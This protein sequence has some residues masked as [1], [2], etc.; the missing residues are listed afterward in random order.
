MRDAGKPALDLI[1]P[2]GDNDDLQLTSAADGVMFDIKATGHPMKLGWTRAGN[3]DA[4]LVLDR[5]HNGTIDDGTELFGNY[6]PQPAVKSKGELNGF[7]ALAVFDEPAQGVNGDG[8]ITAADAIYSSL[9][10]WKDLNHDGISQP[11]ELTTL[12]AEGVRAISLHYVRSKQTD[13]YGNQYRYRGHVTMDRH[14]FEHGIRQ[15]ID[16]FLVTAQTNMT[17]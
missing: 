10:L 3:N 8:Q 12:E 5:N 16:V 4:F 14:A 2:R 15:A 17:H 1:E 6:T 9:R 13:Q 7:R 11:N